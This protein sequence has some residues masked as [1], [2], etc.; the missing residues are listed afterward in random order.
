MRRFFSPSRFR[1]CFF[2]IRVQGR[3]QEIL[4]LK[5]RFSWIVWGGENLGFDGGWGGSSLGYVFF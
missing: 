2:V 1:S 5:M 4:Q 3:E